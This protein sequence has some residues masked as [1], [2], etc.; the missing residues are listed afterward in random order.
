MLGDQERVAHHYARAVRA[1]WEAGDPPRGLE[2]GKDAL[3]ELEAAPD[4]AGLADLLHETGRAYY[5]NGFADQALPILERA[6]QM[7]EATNAVAVQV[8]AL[9]SLGTAGTSA[10]GQPL[11]ESVR[12][13]EQAVQLG[14][15]HDL[16]DEESRALNNL[17]VIKTH[18][19]GDLSGTRQAMARAEALAQQTGSTGIWLFYAGAACF[20]AL[21]EGDLKW[22]AERLPQLSE[23][24]IETPTAVTSGFNSRSPEGGL[25]R[26]LGELEQAMEL[27]RTLHRE[28]V[29]AG[30]YNNVFISA[31][32][33]ADAAVEAGRHLDEA[34]EMLA[35]VWRGHQ[36]GG[37]VWPRSMEARVLAAQ[38]K[39]HEA[40]A[41]LREA[42]EANGDGLFG[43]SP[44]WL[45]IAEAELAGAK[46]DWAAAAQAYSDAAAAAEK[47]GMRW[48]RAH[49]QWRWAE[50][51]VSA[52]DGQAP[53]QAIELLQQAR[54]GFGHCGAPIY[55]ERMDARLKDLKAT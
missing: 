19:V 4:S 24:R 54:E 46:Q 51:L 11:E 55:A 18:Q 37:P 16:P 12:L 14:R 29:E 20:Y 25:L 52:A 39:L 23:A 5:F 2:L 13:L 31:V 6:F 3:A 27:L 17:S 47:S 45:G 8:E 53:E 30:E 44:V 50:A 40:D 43:L 49:I 38:G 22:V 21:L 1:A 28:T 34:Q 9:V 42:Q 48:H 26:L 35:A 10:A 41:S 7:A 15:T 32:Y 36:F 33:Y